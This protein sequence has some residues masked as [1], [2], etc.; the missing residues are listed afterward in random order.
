MKSTSSPARVA[1]LGHLLVAAAGRVDAG[2][3]DAAVLGRIA[4][5]VRWPKGPTRKR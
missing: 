3:D 1:Q 5:P 2:H 4:I